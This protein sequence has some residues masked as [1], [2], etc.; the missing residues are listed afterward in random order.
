VHIAAAEWIKP[1]ACS[2]GSGIDAGCKS[3]LQ[4]AW[5]HVR[6]DIAREPIGDERPW[7]SAETLAAETGEKVGT[8][9]DRLRKLTAAGWVRWEKRAWSLAWRV[10]F[11]HATPVEAGATPVACDSSDHEVRLELP[12]SATLVTGEC[13]SSRTKLS[14]DQDIERSQEHT[15]AGEP[16]PVEGHPCTVADSPEVTHASPT[17]RPAGGVKAGEN[18]PG[19]NARPARKRK[20]PKP[21]Q[22]GFDLPDPEPV[23]PLEIAHAELLADHERLR[24][25]AFAHHREKPPAWPAPFTGSGKAIRAGLRQALRDHGPEVCRAALERRAAEWRGS[26]VNAIKHSLDNMWSAS[27]LVHV[28]PGSTRSRASPTRGLPVEP[29]APDRTY[30]FE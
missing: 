24:A 16:A 11:A 25:E 15:T 21:R 8:V 13:D 12:E 19:T 22:Q 14:H 28:L 26:V 18:A 6:W 5:D 23:D 27:S 3:T 29:D 17:P 20:P 10:P 2:R 4:A 30:R 1:L 9:R 7:A